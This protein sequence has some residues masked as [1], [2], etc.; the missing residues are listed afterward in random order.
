MR[1]VEIPILPGM[2]R[3]SLVT[4]NLR[5]RN[6]IIKVG[7]KLKITCPEL[8]LSFDTELV[9]CATRFRDR[10]NF[11]KIFTAYNASQDDVLVL[12]ERSKNQWELTVRKRPSGHV[13]KINAV[14]RNKQDENST[15]ATPERLK[16]GYRDV[17]ADGRRER[18]PG[19][20][21]R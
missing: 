21:A 4:L 16:N 12:T 20:G 9:I 8:G 5:K 14:K 2:I 7:E 15:T 11:T 17:P 1:I 10:K 18:K 6:N 13:E 3:Q 19:K